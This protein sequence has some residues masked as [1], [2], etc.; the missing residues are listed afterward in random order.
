M[1]LKT[2]RP[3]QEEA[4]DRAMQHDGFFLFMEQR[5][6]KTLTALNIVDQRKPRYVLII[7]VKKGVRVWNKEIKESIK[8]DWPCTISVTYYQDAYKHRKMW[9]ELFRRRKAQ[10]ETTMVICD[11]CHYLKKR[12]S[13][14]SRV[15]RSLGKLATYRLGLTGTPLSPRS[16]VKRRKLVVTSGLQD[17]WAQFAFIDPNVLGTATAFEERYLKKGGFRGFQVV[18]YRNTKEL[19]RLIHEYSYRKLLKE[20]QKKR[21]KIKRTKLF[22]ELDK[23]TRRAYD[24]M[25]RKMYT[26]VDGRK[27]TIPLIMSRSTK[28][29]QIAGGFIKDTEEG[30]IIDLGFAKLEMLQKRLERIFRK[31]HG[32][33]VVVCAKFTHELDLIARLCSSMD[34]THQLIKGGVDFDGTFD[35]QVMLLQVASGVA[36]DLSAADDFFFYSLPHKHIDYEQARFRIL[37]YHKRQARFWFLLAKRTIDELVYEACTKKKDLVSLILDYRRNQNEQ[38]DCNRRSRPV[39]F[40]LRQ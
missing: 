36:I 40:R 27:V 19:K 1:I 30:D 32:K 16:N 24:L 12:G 35:T 25:E 33:K 37:S 21:T 15:V 4:S 28:L 31:D 14:H 8:P 10:G 20:V 3:Y 13:W 17:I 6:G 9:R 38:F 18:G 29:Q 22:C 23:K 2:L 39:H 26:I 5:T 11:E 34:L 7:T